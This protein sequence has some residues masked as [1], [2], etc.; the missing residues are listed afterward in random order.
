MRKVGL[1]V[2]LLLC[3]C[4]EG[5]ADAKRR[6]PPTRSQARTDCRTGP[7]QGSPAVGSLTERVQRDMQHGEERH[8]REERWES[9]FGRDWE[10]VFEDHE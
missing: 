2:G 5:Q 3:A 6:E 7:A 9:T 8:P 1:V 10:Q 4:C